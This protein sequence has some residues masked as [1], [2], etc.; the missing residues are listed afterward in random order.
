MMRLIMEAVMIIAV[1][2][3]LFFM[4][5]VTKNEQDSDLPDSDKDRR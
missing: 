1:V 2:S 5:K 4:T 3:C